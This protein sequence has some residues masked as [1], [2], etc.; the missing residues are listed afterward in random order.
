MPV[1]P[2]MNLSLPDPSVTLGPE[3]ASQ[4]N[5]ALGADGGGVSEHDH[6]PGKGVPVPSSGIGIDAALS[7]NGYAATNLLAT[8]YEIQEDTPDG[9]SLLYFKGVD[10]YA[11]D[12]NGVD[13]RITENGAISAAS[14][15][16]ITGLSSPASASFGADTFT[17]LYDTDLYA[18]MASGPIVLHRDGETAPNDVT[19]TPPAGL[20]ASY[21][22]TLP[23]SLPGGDGYLYSTSSGQLAFSTTALANSVNTAS[24]QSGAVTR[25]KQASVGQ[26]ISGGCGAFTTGSTTNVQVTNLSVTITTTG[27]PVVVTCIADNSISSGNSFGFFAYGDSSS[28]PATGYAEIVVSGDASTLISLFKMHNPELVDILDETVVYPPSSLW[29]LWAGGAGT[30][31]F[32]VNIRAGSSITNASAYHMRLIAYEL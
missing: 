28:D 16:G 24:I 6:T 30:Y 25:A 12:G 11:V 29:T 23:A 21:E 17:W 2:S 19:I 22:L 27:R 20:A 32:T 15:G 7:F 5:D 4:L 10:L 14:I 3:W 13:I 9:T 26:Q 1:T 18:L 8:Q 31:T